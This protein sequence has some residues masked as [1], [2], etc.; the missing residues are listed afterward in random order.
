[1]N[2]FEQMAADM[3]GI[4]MTDAYALTKKFKTDVDF[5]Q[6][7]ESSAM[8]RG[9]TLLDTILEYCDTNDIDEDVVAKL[10]SPSLKEKIQQ[11][12][13]ENKLMVATG[14]TLDF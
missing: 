14:G 10:L 11:E 8:K 5:S 12:A 13:I 2:K 1:M 7:I 6:F 9:E 4:T 3:G